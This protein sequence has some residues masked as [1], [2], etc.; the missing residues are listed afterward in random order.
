MTFYWNTFQEAAFQL[1]AAIELGLSLPSGTL[2]SLCKDPASELRFNRY[3]KVP[4]SVLAEGKKQR[5]AAHTDVGIISMLFQDD[6]SGLEIEDR[7]NSTSGNRSFMP[8]PP[9]K[10]DGQRDVVLL[11]GDTLERWTNRD[12]K[13]TVHRVSSRTSNG[14]EPDAEC[15]ERYSGAFFL[16]PS[17][18]TSVAPLSQFVAEGVQSDFEDI[19]YLA[20]HQQRMAKIYSVY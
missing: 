15:P 3:P 6:V 13:A 10:T 11:V 20:Y 12:I 8:L 16:K 2:R 17:F 7:A 9:G 14:S 19:T 5:A 4:L 1:L 18:D